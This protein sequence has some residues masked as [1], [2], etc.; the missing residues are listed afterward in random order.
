MFLHEGPDLLFLLVS[1]YFYRLKK[2]DVT[3]RIKIGNLMKK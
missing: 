2:K 1:T 3:H